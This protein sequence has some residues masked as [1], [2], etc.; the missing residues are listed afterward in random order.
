LV[1]YIAAAE[2]LGDV[3]IGPAAQEGGNSSLR[4]ARGVACNGACN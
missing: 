2:G 4:R 1:S 3:T